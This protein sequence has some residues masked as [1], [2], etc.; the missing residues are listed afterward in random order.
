[1]DSRRGNGAIVNTNAIVAKTLRQRREELAARLANLDALIAEV[2]GGSSD[3]A[4]AAPK[5]RRRRRS[6]AQIAAIAKAQEARRAS[7][8]AKKAAEAPAE[9]EAPAPARRG[10]GSVRSPRREGANLAEA[11]SAV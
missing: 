7:L 5:Q 3:G 8:A 4:G 2:L 11:A 9:A 1:M 10:S 6:P